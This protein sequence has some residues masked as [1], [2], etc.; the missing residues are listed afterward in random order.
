MRWSKL[1]Q[2]IESA[3]AEDVRR[4][5][6]LW[7][8]RYERAGD[9]YGRSWIT[10]DGQQVISMC[11][12][13]GGDIAMPG[14]RPDGL[15]ASDDDLARLA[16]ELDLLEQE[17][18]RSG[19]ESEPPLSWIKKDA[20]GRKTEGQMTLADH[21]RGRAGYLRQAIATAQDQAGVLSIA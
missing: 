7:T 19:L 4:R 5:V 2:L 6:Q 17:W 8:T 3:F 16:G 11:D 12:Y 10:I 21:L 20:D 9:R 18:L 1:K 15:K 13:K 14:A